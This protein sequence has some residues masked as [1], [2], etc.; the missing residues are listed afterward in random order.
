MKKKTRSRSLYHVKYNV[1]ERTIFLH[2]EIKPQTSFLLNRAV[3]TILQDCS[4]IQK[5]IFFFIDSPGGSFDAT[6][7]IWH[8]FAPFS[9]QLITIARRQVS[10][11]GILLLELGKLRLATPATVFLIH[12][13]A[14][15]VPGKN[16]YLNGAEFLKNFNQ[17]SITN[18]LQLTMLT[19]HGSLPSQILP[20]LISENDTFF[21]AKEAK[22]LKLIDGVIKTGKLLKIKEEA[23]RKFRA[24]KDA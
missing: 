3:K 11:C 18:S 9:D 24:I 15:L 1:K 10:S 20:M 16:Q 6:V 5:P 22:Q 12:G 17:T 19:M 8:T 23:L 4:C 7:A 2:G 14:M 21:R 13:A